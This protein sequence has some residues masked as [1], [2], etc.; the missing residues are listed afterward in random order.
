MAFRDGPGGEGGR[1][2]GLAIVE[3]FVPGALRPRESC[4]TRLRQPSIAS[5]PSSSPDQ[6]VFSGR[7]EDG[8]FAKRSLAAL[9]EPVCSRRSVHTFFHYFIR[10][11]GLMRAVVSG[12]TGGVE[13]I[14]RGSLIT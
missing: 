5:R 3:Q 4:S 11:P 1:K 2:P 6:R 12:G 9:A 13:K 8:A 7:L 14:F 10:S